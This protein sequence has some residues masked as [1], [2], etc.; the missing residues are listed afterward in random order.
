MQ[1]SE[2]RQGRLFILRLED[3][4]IVHEA[5]EEFARKKTIRAAAVIAVGGAD[6]GSRLVVGP[7]EGRSRPIHPLEH[8][9][10]DVHEVAGVGTIFPNG[11]GEP[12]LH[13]HV[14]S[15]RRDKT[16][17]GCVRAGVKVWHVLEI[18]LIEI[19]DT[20]ARRLKDTQ[21]GFEL[22]TIG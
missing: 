4:E 9:L 14:A 17:T 12:V 10:E 15:G 6:G 20:G 5:I 22:L 13:M 18:I 2:A 19:V 7:E 11:D 8:V 16:V 3:G 21:T 1:Y